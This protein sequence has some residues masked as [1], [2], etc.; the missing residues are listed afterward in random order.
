MAPAWTK[1]GPAMLFREFYPLLKLLKSCF[2][3]QQ[4]KLHQTL[5]KHGP[6]L[7]LACFQKF[8]TAWAC[9]SPKIKWAQS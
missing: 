5:S 3:S 2:A 8:D 9:V 6:N 7:V 4:V 1:H